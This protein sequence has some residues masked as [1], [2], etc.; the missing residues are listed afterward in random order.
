MVKPLAFKGEKKSRKR[1]ANELE[2]TLA[3]K[4]SVAEN[5]VQDDDSWVAAESATDI[6]GP[7]V[8]VLPSSTISNCIACDTS[9]TVSISELENVAEGDIASVEP[10]DVRQVWIATKIAGTESFSFKGYHGR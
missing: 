2:P 5:S 8:L 3:P 1:K 6:N 9:G 7:I 4:A 10:H